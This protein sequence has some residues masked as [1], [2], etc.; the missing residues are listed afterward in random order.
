VDAAVTAVFT[1]VWVS[2]LLVGVAFAGRWAYGEWSWRQ[3]LR[4]PRLTMAE[5][6]AALRAEE[7]PALPELAG[8]VA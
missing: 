7:R 2:L 6:T 4:G 1:V 3:E 5:P 8:N